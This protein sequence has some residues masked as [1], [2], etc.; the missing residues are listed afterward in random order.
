LSFPFIRTSNDGDDVDAHQI[1]LVQD[2]FERLEPIAPQAAALFYNN[3]FAIDPALR[4]MFPGD[5]A[6]QGAKLMDMI[7][8]GVRLLGDPER[9]VPVL[10]ALGRRHDAYG[11]RDDHYVTVGV[12]LM[13]TLEKG[14]GPVFTPSVRAAWRIAYQFMADQ[15]MRGARNAMPDEETDYAAA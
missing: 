7:G 11:V 2:S 3:L 8:A 15:M 13:W 12:A 9:L 4:P 14:L 1:K 6:A 5:M 10:R